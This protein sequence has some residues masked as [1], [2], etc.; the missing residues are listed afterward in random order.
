MAEFSKEWIEKEKL[1]MTPDFS[2]KSIFKKLKEGESKSIICEGYGI[3]KI[4]N[5]D[6]V[7]FL[8]IKGKKVS[9]E[10]LTGEKLEKDDSFNPLWWMI[11][12]I[13]ILWIIS[14]VAVPYLFGE[15]KNGESFFDRVGI[16]TF[17]DMFGGINALFSGI[18]LAGIIFTIFLQRKELKLQRKEL[19][20][21]REEFTTQNETLRKQRF[22]NTFFQLLNL[23]HEIVDKL[24]FGKKEKR[25]V[26]EY[27]IGVLKNKFPK[28]Y[29]L[30][31][32]GPPSIERIE[33]ERIQIDESYRSFYFDSDFDALLSHYFRNL[34]H[35]F[36][37]VY[38][39]ELIL[40]EEKKFYS[41]IV[42]AQI[43]PNE[44]ILIFYNSMMEG[45]GKPKFLFLIKEYN[46]LK[47]MNSDLIK[48]TW[49]KEVFKKLISEVE[50]PF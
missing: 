33:T 44:L 50:N 16:G 4:I 6:S 21:T 30:E 9:Y 32:D 5:D 13:V 19:K 40:L 3:T 49:H 10:D 31:E 39:S 34:Y 17:G 25:E 28:G 26:F 24:H 37:Y 20:N 7:C 36:K 48:G 47:N 23:H 42:R 1:E 43:S 41:K 35:I 15:E 18:A 27:A 29:T 22:E 46:I 14:L 45:L 12:G 2:I 11:F 38:Q 8:E